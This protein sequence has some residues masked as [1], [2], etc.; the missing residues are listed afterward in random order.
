[1]YSAETAGQPQVV[2]SWGVQKVVQLW[3]ISVQMRGGAVQ[4]IQQRN[5]P[6]FRVGDPVLVN[7]NNI[8]PWN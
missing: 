6:L 3:D 7:G 1:M 4:V 8:L 2:D 5:E